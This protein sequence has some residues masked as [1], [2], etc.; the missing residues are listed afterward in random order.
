MPSE[1]E[2]Y[3]SGIPVDLDTKGLQNMFSA[4]GPVERVKIIQPTN[5]N[6]STCI[7]F[8]TFK[9]KSAAAT[10][11]DM[12][13]THKIGSH[14][15]RCNYSAGEERD[16]GGDRDR[17]LPPLPPSSS[18][19]GISTDYRA[20]QSPLNQ[21]NSSYDDS[22][23][24]IDLTKHYA[25]AYI[26]RRNANPAYSAPTYAERNDPPAPSPRQNGHSE[27]R[28]L[29][30]LA[31]PP[32]YKSRSPVAQPSTPSSGPSSQAKPQQASELKSAAPKHEP[33]APA[34]AVESGFPDPRAEILEMLNSLNDKNTNKG[35]KITQNDSLEIGRFYAI[36]ITHVIT[37]SNFFVQL[38]SSEKKT[39]NVMNNVNNCYINEEIQQFCDTEKSSIRCKLAGIRPEGS[40]SW[41]PSSIQILENLNRKFTL[42]L[43]VVDKEEFEPASGR[44]EYIYSVDVI[45]N[46]KDSLSQILVE[47]KCASGIETDTQETPAAEAERASSRLSR[48]QSSSYDQSE[49]DNEVSNIN[50]AKLEKKVQITKIYRPEPIKLGLDDMPVMDVKKTIAP[51]SQFIVYAQRINSF[52]IENTL[53]VAE[54]QEKVEVVCQKIIDELAKYDPLDQADAELMRKHLP[55]KGDLVYAK[56]REDDSWYRCVVTNCSQEKRK[57]EVFFLD[58]GNTEVNQLD[59]ILLGWKQEHVSLFHEY[60]P[61]AIKC[62]FYGVRP[63]SKDEF[64]DEDNAYFKELTV[65]RL[66]AA[67]LISYNEKDKTCEVNLHEMQT[68]TEVDE[69]SVLRDLLAKGTAEFPKFNQLIQTITTQEQVNF[70]SNLLSKLCTLTKG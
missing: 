29:S 7:G 51:D 47:C 50:A 41:N 2:L 37:P 43:K 62:T 42:E 27:Q 70:Y 12:F 22:N 60:E 58:F 61:Q 39:G 54:I 11:L 24:D 65:D 4:A 35:L 6:Y 34:A 28:V 31:E 19:G 44:F 26:K 15:I 3:V 57:Y 1:I 14:V 33:V 16:R 20:R 53:M 46:G 63:V 38:K 9:T 5:N 30:P 69:H 21:V 67:D 68:E 23:Q 8:V 52:Y 59:E 56:Y 40:S 45:L 66:F 48:K 36:K 13:R 55:E 64:S 49:T 17:A 32:S 10:A 18:S 25:Q